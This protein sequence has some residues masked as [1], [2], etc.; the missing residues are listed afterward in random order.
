VRPFHVVC[1]IWSHRDVVEGQQGSAQKGFESC[2]WEELL[3]CLARK[4]GQ[5]GGLG[6]G[7]TGMERPVCF[8]WR[9][10]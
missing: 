3:H 1:D 4:S 10:Q 8:M 9:I 2:C 7:P 6:V 5:L